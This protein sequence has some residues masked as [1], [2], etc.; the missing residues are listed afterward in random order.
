MCKSISLVDRR[1]RYCKLPSSLLKHP[2]LDK[3]VLV[4][5]CICVCASEWK[6]DPERERK[7]EYKKAVEIQT[8]MRV[9]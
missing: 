1:S 6:R 4:C 2:V 9:V 8:N 7:K 3:C 5:A